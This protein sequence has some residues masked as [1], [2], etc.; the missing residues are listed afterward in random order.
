M[1]SATFDV[2]GVTYVARSLDGDQA[3][4]AWAHG[5]P[6]QRARRSAR[7]GIAR[8][9]TL[10]I[11]AC[12]GSA[13]ISFAVAVRG[14]PE[15]LLAVALLLAAAGLVAFLLTLDSVRTVQ[16]STPDVVKVPDEVRALIP[17]RA[18]DRRTIWRCSMA[19][20]TEVALG[21]TIGWDLNIDRASDVQRA[22]RALARYAAAYRA[23]EATCHELGLPVRPPATRL[24]D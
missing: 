19:I 10:L 12:L 3:A 14:A 11:A 15:P 13:V 23:Y 5:A 9:L 6:D 24:P 1:T 22:R 16:G 7:R 8:A 21:E 4:V 20:N 2:D 18:L 17:F